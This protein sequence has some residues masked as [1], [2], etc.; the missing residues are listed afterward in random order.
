V[1]RSLNTPT[2]GVLVA[3]GREV[4]W[5]DE[6]AV[7]R[8]RGRAPA[9]GS[10]GQ[11][12]DA[13]QW[14]AGIQGSSPPRALRRARLLALG[15]SAVATSG[16]DETVSVRDVDGTAT[17]V[18]AAV[19]Q[20]TGL[21][22]TEV[23]SG[24]DLLAV[25]VG[26]AAPN[27]LGAAAP[28]GLGAAALAVIAV[29]T[30]TEPVKV[31]PRGAGIDPADWMAL[32]ESVRDARR[33][34]F[35]HRSNPDRLLEALPSE[36]STPLAMATAVLLHAAVRRTPVLVD[37]LGSVAAAALAHQVQPRAARYWRV[38]DS[39]IHPAHALAL[40]RL[41]QRPLLHWDTALADGSAVLLAVNAL[42]LAIARSNGAA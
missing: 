28:N 42:Q 36:D 2:D 16:D 10:W 27:G 30:N 32:A 23:D 40:A 34:A 3:I 12:A 35:E 24:A 14:L 5:P 37:G 41:G 26:P 39:S 1:S 22:D 25:V 17:T 33:L 18:A 38:A 19:E 4:D 11:L 8:E 20:G 9:D 7:G 31:L 29:V 6:E 21:V 13:T 15:G